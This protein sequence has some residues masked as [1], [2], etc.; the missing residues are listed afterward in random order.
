MGN[1]QGTHTHTEP[2]HKG[3]CGG[4]RGGE[5]WCMCTILVFV[6]ILAHTNKTQ[7]ELDMMMFNCR[8]YLNQICSMH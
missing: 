4:L 5:W 6:K 8:F 3:I 1:R 7:A 2:P